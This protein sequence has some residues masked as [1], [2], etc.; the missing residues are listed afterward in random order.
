MVCL[1]FLTKRPFIQ[2]RNLVF[3]GSIILFT[4]SLA[5]AQEQV[6]DRPFRSGEELLY[7]I[8]YNWKFVWI[9]AG[10]VKFTVKEDV[11]TLVFEV[12]GKSFSSYD[13]FFKVRDYY[14]S[15]VSK[16]SLLPYNFWRE[17]QEGNYFRFDSLNFDYQNKQVHEYFG[18]TKETAKEYHFDLPSLTHDMVSV[19]YHLRTYPIET[20]EEGE[21]IPVRIFFDKEF[22]ELD[23]N[24]IGKETKKIRDLGRREVYHFQPEL[25]EGY[26]FNE[27]DFMDIWISDD[28]YRLPLLIESP[29]KYGKVKAILKEA[30]LNE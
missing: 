5:K 3:I 20:F 21:E 10:E 16:Q 4:G 30:K 13:S 8:Y 17:I 11:D 9:P 27:G 14:C 2:I 1:L 22:F 29:I 18:K 12:T 19:I 28:G 26:V 24:F 15:K 7:T 25:I 23:I 6:L